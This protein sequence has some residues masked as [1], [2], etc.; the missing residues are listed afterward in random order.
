VTRSVF[1]APPE[2]VPRDLETAPV[3]RV[4]TDLAGTHALVATMLARRSDFGITRIG[5]VTRLDRI[6][7]PVVQVA[8]PLSLSNAVSQGKGMT[9]VEAAASALMEE[10]EV[11]AGE[12]IPSTRLREATTRDVGERACALYSRAVVA[13]DRRNWERVPLAWLDGWDLFTARPTPVPAALVDTVYTV[14]SPHPRL[15]PRTT[16]GLGAGATL[17]DATVHAAL[18]I[19]ERDAVAAAHERPHFFDLNQVDLTT[20]VGGTSRD[21]LDRIGAAGLLVGAWRVPA[22]HDLPVYWCHVMEDDRRAELAPLPASGFSCGLSHDRALAGAL[23]EAC[24]ARLAAISG[25]REDITRRVYPKNHDRGALAAWREQLA[26]PPRPRPFRTDAGPAAP[27]L[28]RALDGMRAAG[29][30]AAIVVPLLRD[31][32]NGLFVVRVVAPPLRPAPNL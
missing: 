16:T 19:L 18:E 5:S 15:L 13:E 23:L 32:E 27:P 14:P 2:T 12:Q 10:L 29:A 7:V 11:F 1:A 9:L 28:R 24:Q 6:G 26:T 3:A 22:P 17:A 8:R 25:A 4:E 30:L 21:L 31:M 20:V